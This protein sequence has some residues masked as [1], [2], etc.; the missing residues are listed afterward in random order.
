M[1]SMKKKMRIS[2]LCSTAL[3]SLWV[4]GAE[5]VK[6]TEDRF[7]TFMKDM[8]A[9]KSL[10]L[11]QKTWVGQNTILQQALTEMGEDLTGYQ[12][13]FQHQTKDSLTQLVMDSTHQTFEAWKGTL[14]TTFSYILREVRST[15]GLLVEREGLRVA[16]TDHGTK[17]EHYKTLIH[18]ENTKKDAFQSWQ[19]ALPQKLEVMQSSYTEDQSEVTNVKKSMES[20][21]KSLE[22][23][24]KRHGELKERQGQW[25][26]YYKEGARYTTPSTGSLVHAVSR[27]YLGSDPYYWVARLEGKGDAIGETS[28]TFVVKSL[29][30]FQPGANLMLS[31]WAFKNHPDFSL[32]KLLTPSEKTAHTAL[33]ETVRA[34]HRITTTTFE[35]VIPEGLT[36]ETQQD[37][38]QEPVAAPKVAQEEPRLPEQTREE[39]QALQ[40]TTSTLESVVSAN[41]TLI[42]EKE[43]R[44]A[45]ASQGV[46]EKSAAVTPVV[47]AKAAALAQE[48]QTQK[49]KRLKAEREALQTGKQ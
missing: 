33:E 27:G 16:A 48:T 39:A 9:A 29:E 32:D 17:S 7:M 18:F 41:L 20:N 40:Q 3:L 22:A 24:E 35:S 1:Q 2:L 10:P 44:L 5:A 23:L 46:A 49:K 31:A 14:E 28:S 37:V 4:S 45:E 26:S 12:D 38:P 36:A 25:L 21:Q 13:T 11:S 34:I 8:E 19:T 42:A 30:A 43:E 47:A 6:W 15:S